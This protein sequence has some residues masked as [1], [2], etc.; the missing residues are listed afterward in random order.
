MKY[1][2]EINVTREKNK[3]LIKCIISKYS[4]EIHRLKGHENITIPE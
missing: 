3:Y 4:S 2:L 1:L